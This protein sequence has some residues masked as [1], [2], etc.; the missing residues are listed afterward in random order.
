MAA[1]QSPF[2]VGVSGSNAGGLILQNLDQPQLDRSHRLEAL[3]T[4]VQLILKQQI[5]PYTSDEPICV[6]TVCPIKLA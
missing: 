2:A 1:Q 3:Q 4:E 6:Y 5:G